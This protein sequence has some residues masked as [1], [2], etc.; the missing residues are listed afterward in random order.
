MVTKNIFLSVIKKC[1][2]L[3][4]MQRSNFLHQITENCIRT[5]WLLS[6]AT[7]KA[8]DSARL[9][10]GCFCELFCCLDST[11]NLITSLIDRFC[12]KETK[13]KASLWDVLSSV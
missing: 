8:A 12:K 11:H 3:N 1:Q 13:S 10:A 2:F 4:Q 5:L 6:A 7:G 9:A